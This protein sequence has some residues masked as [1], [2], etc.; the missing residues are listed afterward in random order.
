LIADT[1]NKVK[2][3]ARITIR[4]LAGAYGVSTDTTYKI[5]TETLC[6]LE[7]LAKCVKVVH[8][9]PA[10]AESVAVQSFHHCHAPA[11]H[12]LAG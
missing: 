6:L 3:N 2:K 12:G 8:R 11:L 4:T 7:K 5:L 10:A 1:T 9:G